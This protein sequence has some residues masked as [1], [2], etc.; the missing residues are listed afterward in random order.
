[1][2]K[3]KLP[4]NLL[5]GYIFILITTIIWAAAGPI[6]KYTLDYIPPLTFLFLRFLIACIIFLPYTVYE[7]QK[8]RINPKDYLNFFILG[9]FSQTSLAL[10][11]LALNY[12]TAID[13]AVIGILGSIMSVVAGKY[14]YNDKVNGNT[15]KGLLLA[16]IGTLIVVMEPLIIDGGNNVNITHRLIGNSLLFLYNVVWVLF[17][18]WSKMSMGET[19]KLL[20]KSLSFIHLK[21]MT[22]S[23][24]PTLIT[25]VCMFVGLFTSV[26]LA[27]IEISNGNGF[28]VLELG[29][30]GV[31]GLLYMSLF[32]SLVGYILYQKALEYVKT[33][34][35]AFFHYLSPLFTLP[36]AFVLL[37]EIPTRIVVAGSIIIAVGVYIGEINNSNK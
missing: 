22:K 16:S 14:F 7:I 36:V 5:K 31:L 9:I 8:V 19:S 20:K 17:I 3:S 6:I 35:I 10:I 18:I 30:N 34:D 15:K 1:M 24:P 25:A 2:F 4:D 28:N 21:P 29:I 26:P 23:Y 27:M 13:N 37:G 12:T 32:S 33:S 11:F